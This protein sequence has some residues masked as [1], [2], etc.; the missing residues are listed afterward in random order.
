MKDIIFGED[1]WV[2]KLNQNISE[3]KRAIKRVSNDQIMFDGDIE[4]TSKWFTGNAIIGNSTDPLS[5]VDSNV[6]D[7]YVDDY[8]LNI[9][10]GNIYKCVLAGIPLVAKWSYT[11]NIKGNTG[12]RGSKWYVGTAITSTDPTAVIELDIA[13]VNAM[14]DDQY[15]NNQTGLIY[16]CIEITETKSKWQY[17]G[18]LVESIANQVVE[19]THMLTLVSNQNGIINGD[20]SIC[21]RTSKDGTK[22]FKYGG[23]DG[24]NL[25]TVDRWQAIQSATGITCTIDPR[26]SAAS[27]R[28][29]LSVE[30][31]VK[32]LNAQFAIKQILEDGT[33]SV[34]KNTLSFEYFTGTV[35]ITAIIREKGTSNKICELILPLNSGFTKK[36]ITFDILDNS[37]QYEVL[38]QTDVQA[39]SITSFYLSNVKLD[40]GDRATPFVPRLRAQ[41]EYIC[42]LYFERIGN[43]GSSALASLMGSG[44]TTFDGFATCT[45][46]KRI[47]NPVVTISAMN[48]YRVYTGSFAEPILTLTGGSDDGRT[49]FLTGTTGG[50]LSRGYAAILQRTDSATSAWIDVDAELR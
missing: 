22:V 4:G 26:Y 39:Y 45:V 18:T 7:A 24:V 12:V 41:E 40:R 30:N 14:K 17:K 34:G 37:K 11:G 49:I 9:D 50:G 33:L 44:T 20:F 35:N 36:Q 43:G 47:D 25:Y 15:L 23:I 3:I 28:K 10:N 1:G 32:P 42:K 13:T 19:N 31:L 21:Q 6:S 29:Y 5:F 27:G 8:Y 16:G 48:Q 38:F 46:R 2:R